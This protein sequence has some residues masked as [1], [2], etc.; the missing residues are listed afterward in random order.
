MSGILSRGI[1]TPVSIANG[2]TG[3]ATQNFIDITTNQTVTG[4]KTFA[5][6]VKTVRLS[7]TGGTALATTD[8]AISSG[9]GTGRS[10]TATTG[11]DSKGTVTVRSGTTNSANPTV[12]LTFKDGTWTTAP[13]AVAKLVAPTDSLMT[14]IVETTNATTMTL[15]LYGTPEE[16]VD[17]TFKFIVVGN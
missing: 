2:G 16:G 17:Y 12:I 3:S 15:T 8:F 9:W 14:P 7:T 11:T 4:T 13:F 5:T 1:A 6:A 10:V